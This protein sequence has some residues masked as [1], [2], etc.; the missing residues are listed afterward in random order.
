MMSKKEAQSN[1]ANL[2]YWEF[3]CRLQRKNA[4]TSD[5]LHNELCIRKVKFT[6]RALKSAKANGPLGSHDIR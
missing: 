2:A 1:T 6:P 5:A 4:P 3:G